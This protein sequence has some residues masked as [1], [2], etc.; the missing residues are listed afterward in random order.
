MD[1]ETLSALTIPLFT[2]AIGYLTNWSGVWMLFY[3]VRFAGVRFPGLA[4]LAHLLPRRVQQVPGVMKGG[5]GWQGI[6]PSRAAKMGSIAVDKGIAKIGG[7]RDFYEQLQPDQIAEQILASSRDDIREVVERTIERE[8]PRLWRDMPQRV[9]EAVHARVQQQLP[10]I[11]HQLTAQIGEHVDQLLDVKLMVIRHIEANPE[12]GNRIFLEV[13]R[14][15]LR[16]VINFGFLFGFLQGI[17][18]VFITHALPY[19][20]VLP[21][22]GVII[23]Y[24]TNWVA[25]WMIF[26][27]TEPRRLGPLKLQGLF[28]RRQPEVA[29]V[30]AEIIADD[31]VTAANIGDELLNGRRADRTR[32][33]I[34]DAMRPA[35][36]RS[37]GSAH[38]AVRVAVGSRRYDAIREGLASE[39]VDYTVTPLSDP[40]FN[41]RQAAAMRS[42]VSERIAALPHR[43]FAE[44]LRSAMREDEWLLLLHGAVLGFAAG[45]LHLAIFGPG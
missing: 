34:E 7:P 45:L 26:E 23:G 14:R 32:R 40:E 10:E 41:R 16:L 4:R 9:R 27:P 24:V 8:H 11:V 33:M 22:G 37:L 20:W 38:S 30:Y 28:L 17:P 21:I 39:A 5:V 42:L 12:L 15:E 43:D 1:S 3:P 36:D 19:W 29:E 18:L 25:L 35:I 44:M 2:G 13:G 6:I 31:I